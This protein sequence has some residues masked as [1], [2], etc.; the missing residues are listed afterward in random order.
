METNKSGVASRF[1]FAAALL[2]GVLVTS[3]PGAEI[4]KNEYKVRGHTV[5]LARL[6]RVIADK[7]KEVEKVKVVSVDE[8]IYFRSH[9][10]FIFFDMEITTSDGKKYHFSECTLDGVI[11]RVVN[12]RSDQATLEEIDIDFAE[13]APAASGKGRRFRVRK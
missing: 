3:A 9:K 2:L 12:C 11:K 10:T 8:D 6:E 1:F 13:L 5:S 7:L 4:L